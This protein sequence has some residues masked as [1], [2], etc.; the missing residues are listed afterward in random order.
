MNK[1][2][3]M[4]TVK[5]GDRGMAVSTLQ[6]MLN[7]IPDGIF[8]EITEDAVKDFQRAHGLQAD[9]IAGPQTWGRLGVAPTPQARWIDEIIVHC[10]AT[11]EGKPVTVKQIREWHVNG[12]GWKDIGYH[13]V[14]YLDGSV[15]NGRPVSMVGA[16]CEGHNARSIGVCYVGGCDKDGKTP[17]DTRRP[18]QKTALRQLL[19]RLKM[20]YANAK[21]YSHRDFA[22]KACPSF[23]ATAE[24][25]DL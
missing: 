23:D 13:Y 1:I 15:H 18:I 16:H 4:E 17:K 2:G 19:K 10:T 9:G 7:C 3:V 11:P 20:T 21:I 8:G 12:R 14:V 22:Q 6:R 5:K 24:Y 25:A